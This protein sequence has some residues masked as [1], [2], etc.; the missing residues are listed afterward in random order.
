MIEVKSV[1]IWINAR[2]RTAQP[3]PINGMSLAAV[4]GYITPPTEDPDATIPIAAAR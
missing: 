2:V 1:T 4:M 3:N